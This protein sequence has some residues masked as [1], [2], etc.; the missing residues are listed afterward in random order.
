[1]VLLD[2]RRPEEAARAFAAALAVRP[3][4]TLARLRLAAILAQTNRCD[5]AITLLDDGRR[6][7]AN[8]PVFAQAS[9]QLR[10][11]CAA[12]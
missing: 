12:Q 1:M 4:L 3:D 8:D 5:E 9:Q 10:T 7:A 6:F 2:L 11:A